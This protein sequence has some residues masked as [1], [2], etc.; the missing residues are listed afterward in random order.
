MH[1]TDGR[2]DGRGATLMRPLREGR[3]FYRVPVQ[4]KRKV[5]G[6]CDTQTDRQT[7]TTKA[8]RIIF[9]VRW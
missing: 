1:V 3:T 9:A 2:T 6:V 7:N 8:N 5:Y 4:S